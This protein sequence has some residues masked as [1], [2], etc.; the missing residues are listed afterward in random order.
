MYE[1]K[2]CVASGLLLCNVNT[3]P[4]WRILKNVKG[5]RIDEKVGNHCSK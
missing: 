1:K 5:L 3:K 2:R 4:R